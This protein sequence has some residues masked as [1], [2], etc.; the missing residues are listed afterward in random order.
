MQT[1]TGNREPTRISADDVLE[2]LSRSEKYKNMTSL[3]S[4]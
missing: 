4:L 3:H 1:R 2:F